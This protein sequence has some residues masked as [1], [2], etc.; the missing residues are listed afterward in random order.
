MK[1]LVYLGP[2]SMEFQ[3]TD[4]PVG[5]VLVRVLGTGLCGTDLKTFFKGH[6][7]FAPPTVLGHEC[8]GRI[9]RA[10]AGCGFSYG[11]LVTVAPYLECGSCAVCAKGLGQL[12]GNKSYISGGC[13]AEYIAAGVDYAKKAFFRIPEPSIAFA[14][15]EPLACVLNGTE[16]LRL[17]DRRKTLIV[18]G[19]P[20]GS[21]FGAVLEERD[22]PFAFVE[23]NPW[24]VSMLER[25]G[26]NVLPTGD[27]PTGEYDQIVLTVNK[28]ELVP[29]YLGAAAPGGNLLLFSGF[30]RQDRTS[31]DP[32]DIHY[33]EV[34]ITGSYG[35]ALSHFISALSLVTASSARFERLVT[36]RLPLERGVEAMG[37][38]QRGEA[39]K[40]VLEP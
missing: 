4:M 10:P 33:R 22:V 13:F 39:M 21:L 38:L 36:H 24:R 35:Y 20:M 30:S 25:W 8:F 11:D 31:V 2:G 7:M 32:Y 12:C 9:E 1:A 5:E 28:P 16:K 40:I 17:D 37:L 19:G 29:Q 6:H 14:L 34:S 18:G 15:V 26:W 23:P 3:E 27:S